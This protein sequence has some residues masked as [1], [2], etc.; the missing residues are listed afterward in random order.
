[1]KIV[2]KDTGFD[3]P[4]IPFR[5]V[6]RGF[7]F[8]IGST[9][10][11]W[12]AGYLDNC[13][14][15]SNIFGVVQLLILETLETYPID[16]PEINGLRE[17]RENGLDFVLHLPVPSNLADKNVNPVEPII[18]IIETFRPLDV[19]SFVLHI[20]DGGEDGGKDC[21]LKL[22][23]QRITEICRRTK[24]DPAKIC[25]E[26]LHAPFATVWEAVAG[27]GVSICFDAGHVIYAGGNP[28]SFIEK[29]GERIRITHIHGVDEKEN[30]LKM[31]DHRP[32]SSLEPGLLKKLL[33]KLESVKFNG[34]VIIENYSVA[35]MVESLRVLSSLFSAKDSV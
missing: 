30:A 31:R 33:D 18:K 4:L 10:Y 27:T 32:L 6:V 16:K 8:K 26:N 11:L 7:P 24:T 2:E 34:P 1:M 13:R 28:F 3:N 22:A 20:E 25:V 17:L 9:S 5:D 21:D 29:Y 23:A 19:L 35:E 14:K 12:P 15:L